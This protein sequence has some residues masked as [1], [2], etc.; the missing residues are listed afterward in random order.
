MS[1]GS[2]SSGGSGS[3]QKALERELKFRVEGL[4][5]VRER[6]V[7]MEAER[8][9]PASFEDNWILDR[10]GEL[11][12]AGCILRLRTDGRGTRVTF[13]GPRTFD[14][15]AKVR[16]EHEIQVEGLDEARQLFEALGY[17]EGAR[18]Q[19]VREEW[20]L[21]S[22]DVAL[23]HTPIGDFVEFEGDR[24]EALAKRCGLDLKKVEQ[25]SYLRLY[26]DYRKEHPE[27]PPEMT[28]P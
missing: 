19:K 14:G 5:F 25:R 23:D 6:L 24:A 27:A 7:E 2:G 8:V 10:D 9:G 20:R 21:G 12:R 4:D 11:E 1:S 15:A 13:K 17:R 26:Q 28:F 18:Y 22:V 16:A 3:K